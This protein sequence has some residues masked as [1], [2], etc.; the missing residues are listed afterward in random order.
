MIFFVGSIRH[1]SP[2]LIW[3]FLFIVAISLLREF[4]LTLPKN[5][6]WLIIIWSIPAFSCSQNVNSEQKIGI[7]KLRYFKTI[8]DTELTAFERSSDSTT[9]IIHPSIQAHTRV[10]EISNRNI[11]FNWIIWNCEAVLL[12]TH[13]SAYRWRALA[14][15]LHIGALRH[16]VMLNAVTLSVVT[17]FFLLFSVFL[18]FP[19][20]CVETMIMNKQKKRWVFALHAAHAQKCT[21]LNSILS[22]SNVW[23]LSLSLCLFFPT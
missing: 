7:W 3:I 2:F 1:E 11:L 23:I 21:N 5:W 13:K 10:L 8:S 22:S 14:N 20:L 15:T 6:T 16:W 4:F 9:T 12:R 18:H 19:F 17:R